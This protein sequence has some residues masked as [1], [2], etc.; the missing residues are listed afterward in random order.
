MKV[1][2]RI[3]RGGSWYYTSEDCRLAC[4]ARIESAFDSRNFCFRA[5]RVL[6]EEERRIGRCLI[7]ESGKPC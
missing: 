7:K 5:V 2:R 3:L 4:R 1:R 6:K